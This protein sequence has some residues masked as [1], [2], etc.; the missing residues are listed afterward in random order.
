MPKIQHTSNKKELRRKLKELEATD[1]GTDDTTVPSTA[2]KSTTMQ[3]PSR[4]TATA[5]NLYQ[6]GP[7]S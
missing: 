4:D 6:T 7:F 5:K 2:V 3:T 1:T